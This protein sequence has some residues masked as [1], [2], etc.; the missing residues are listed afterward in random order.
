MGKTLIVGIDRPFVENKIGKISDFF[1][2]KT[3]MLDN[4]ENHSMRKGYK[5]MAVLFA[6]TAIALFATSCAKE[7]LS[8]EA[9]QR[10]PGLERT[11]SASAKL[12][13]ITDKAY[14]DDYNKVIWETGDALNIN[15]T[16][17]TISTIGPDGTTASFDE[18]TVHANNV[19][20]TDHYWAVYP[21]TLVGAYDGGLPTEFSSTTSLT[22]HFP[23]TQVVNTADMSLS[24]RTYMAAHTSV[25]AGATKVSFSMRNLG[26]VMKLTLQPKAG[27]ADNRVDSLVLTSSNTA[28]SGTFTVSDDHDN[29]TITPTDGVNKLVVKFKD[30]DK[31]YID[32]TGGATV[33]VILPPMASKS[34]NM[35]IYGTFAQF[36]QK[37]ITSANLD[38]NKFY[39]STISNIAFDQP[40]LLGPFSIDASGSQ[41]YFSPGNLQWSATNG[42]TTPTTHVTADGVAGVGTFRFAEHQWDFVGDGTK[43]TVFANGVRCSN[44][45]IDQN[46]TGWVD[47]FSWATSGWNSGAVQYQPYSHTTN[48]THYYPGGA[49]TNSLT[50]AYAYADWGIYNAI[51]DPATNHTFEPGTWR[52][53]TAEE[54]NYLASQRPDY[55]TL[56]ARGGV[57]GMEGL[58]LLPDNWTLPAGVTLTTGL[59]PSVWNE[60]TPE[61]W[62]VMES[63]G[64]VF[65]PVA[66]TRNGS[67]VYDAGIRGRYW[68]STYYSNIMAYYLYFYSAGINSYAYF[69]RNRYDGMA[70]RLVRPVN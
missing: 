37:S 29:P 52:T 35:R 64:A 22:V 61:E 55:R 28:L 15:G 8:N 57:D 16:N 48:S 39:S 58:I 26:A 24:G 67:N 10:I 56:R 31:K 41:I 14:I 21:T 18:S 23:D 53:L 69:D 36:T 32:I 20:G 65:L 51:Y 63:A 59:G 11:I 33:Y 30:G 40:P 47:L 27:N 70:V 62:A 66:G 46:Y 49:Y 54:I 7:D 43:G 3:S 50:G 44:R 5:T 34:I 1:R 12:P 19:S 6:A 17:V 42:G 60:Y 9:Q 4:K 45:L 13:Q 38:R 68:M 25:T 2:K